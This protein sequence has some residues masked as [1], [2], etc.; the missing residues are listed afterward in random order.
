MRLGI[1]PLL[2]T[3]ACGG[4][5]LPAPNRPLD[6]AG[7][8]AQGAIHDASPDSE[9]D[10]D[11]CESPHQTAQTA[12]ATSLSKHVSCLTESDCISMTTPGPCIDGCYYAVR[13]MDLEQVRD[14]ARPLCAEYTRM[15]CKASLL[16]CPASMPARCVQGSCSF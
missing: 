14:A 1:L 16:L 8:E 3:M 11:T 13:V 7:I 5:A 10:A 9:T 15:G 6:A 12:F 4:H 2:L